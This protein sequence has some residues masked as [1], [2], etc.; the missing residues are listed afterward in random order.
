MQI[1]TG[2]LPGSKV[3]CVYRLSVDQAAM[4][5]GPSEEIQDSE[6]EF[7]LATLLQGTYDTPGQR[8]SVPV[9]FQGPEKT[10]LPPGFPE[11]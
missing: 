7:S 1:P 9:L 3:A 4:V 10:Y 6:A 5:G 8:Y 11:A 2:R